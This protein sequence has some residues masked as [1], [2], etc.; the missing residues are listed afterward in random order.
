MIET[1]ERVIVTVNSRD[2]YCVSVTLLMSPLND[3]YKISQG[4][5]C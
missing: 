5:S 1:E 2:F 4:L 3:S